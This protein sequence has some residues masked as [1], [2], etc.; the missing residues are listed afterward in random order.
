MKTSEKSRIDNFLG[1]QHIALA[2]YSRSP[3]K[4]GHE[5]YRILKG[6]G[7][8]LYPVNPAGGRTPD[9]ED[10]YTDLQEL[11]AEVKALLVVT[12]PDV[13]SEVF[14]KA[15]SLGFEYLWIQQMSGSR[16]VYDRLC[17]QHE[18][19]VCGKCIL[20]H[21]Q[22]EGVHKFHRWLVGLVGRLPR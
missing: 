1:Q 11:P 16:K 2:G 21:A 8:T 10:I 15:V 6:K 4:F 7:Y 14:E 3:K 5:V 9:G 13:T 20:L 22:P 19:A 12:K 18:N 17:K